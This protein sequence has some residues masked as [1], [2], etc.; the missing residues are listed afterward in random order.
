MAA[1]DMISFTNSAKLKISPKS[2]IVTSHP[3]LTSEL[4]GKISR[5]GAQ[6]TGV[7]QVADLGTEATAGARR[8]TACR[9]ARIAKAAR[10]G[11]RAK[12][13]GRRTNKGEKLFNTNLWPTMSF[14]LSAFGV[15]QE[16]MKRMRTLA[17]KC[18]AEQSGQCTTST[19]AISFPHDSDPA[20]KLR[21]QIIKDWLS[22]W[23][24]N[25]SERAAWTLAWQRAMPRLQGSRRWNLVRGPIGTTICTLIDGGWTPSGPVRWIE[26][27]A[28]RRIWTFEPGLDPKPV[29]DA[30]STH[31]RAAL[32]AK[33]ATFRNG[34]G[35]TG[36]PD[37]TKLKQ[38]IEWYHRKGL[39][40]HAGAL[41]AIAT[42]A[43][44]P[45]ERRFEAG[46]VTSPIC[47]RCN[48]AV[49]DDFHCYWGCAANRDIQSDD[50]AHTQCLAERAERGRT[51]WPCFWTR[52][53]VP[54]AWVEVPEM[55]D[56]DQ[57]QD[58]WETSDNLAWGP[59]FY[60][61]DGSGGAEPSRA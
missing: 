23:E 28:V 9:T 10:R 38:H 15:S 59:V 11:A 4:V 48:A 37:L 61:T 5:A 14:G 43:T 24:R 25:P 18:A 6:V 47:P 56:E 12:W 39:P 40:G 31:I 8:G 35:L 16:Q 20:I 29:L 45:M 60:Y 36:I 7:A 54:A 26:N 33:A 52:G 55:K 32:W 42:A 50:V 2:S 22:L 51:S 27:G 19:I 46:L 44:W 58:E 41:H 21:R 17:A 53:I 13:L 57:T 30:F 34:T 3:A 49:E 1:M